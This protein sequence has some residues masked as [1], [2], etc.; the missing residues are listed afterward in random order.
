MHRRTLALFPHYIP[1]C[2]FAAHSFNQFHIMRY[3]LIKTQ[4]VNQKMKPNPCL[5]NDETL[6]VLQPAHWS[7]WKK[8]GRVKV[9]GW[10]REIEH[11]HPQVRCSDWN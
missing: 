4:L 7:A 10:G 9:G 3:V 2:Y 8:N 6:S 5:S 11:V 1:F